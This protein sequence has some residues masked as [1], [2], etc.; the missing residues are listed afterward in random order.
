MA[1][2]FI[3]EEVA[4]CN[5]PACHIGDKSDLRKMPSELPPTTH[6]RQSC[7]APSRTR[8]SVLLGNLPPHRL[9]PASDSLLFKALLLRTA[10]RLRR[11]SRPRHDGDAGD[12]FLQAQ[13]G[14]F[15]VLFLAAVRL[16]LDYHDALSGDAL[17]VQPKQAFLQL[18]G[19]R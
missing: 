14:F 1:T 7:K 8:T 19:Q 16:H 2:R 15:L 3:L 5:T 18:F 10:R 6:Y 11:P 4:C 12:H 9:D 17:V 13:Q